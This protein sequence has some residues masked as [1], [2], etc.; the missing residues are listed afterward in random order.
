VLI[1]IA[2]SKE[3]QKWTSGQAKWYRITLQRHILAITKD[4]TATCRIIGK[5]CINEAVYEQHHQR[6]RSHNQEIIPAKIG[7]YEHWKLSDG[8]D[9]RSWVDYGTK[10][11][12]NCFQLTF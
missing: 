1:R 5:K 4:A 6:K 11:K 7:N 8:K 2:T 9:K 12:I 10:W 3:Q